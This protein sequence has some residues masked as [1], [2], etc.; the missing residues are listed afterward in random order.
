MAV[1]K[2]RQNGQ[3]VVVGTG[4]KGEKGDAGNIKDL[5]TELSETSTNAV[6]NKVITSAVSNLIKQDTLSYSQIQP[7]LVNNFQN[8]I[9]IEMLVE[10]SIGIS[11]NKCEFA[12]DGNKFSTSS[13]SIFSSDGRFFFTPSFYDDGKCYFIGSKHIYYYR[14][15]IFEGSQYLYVDRIGVPSPD[16]NASTYDSIVLEHGEGIVPSTTSYIVTYYNMIK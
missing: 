13:A 3:W 1:L 9:K 10:S 8:V 14:L 15:A 6:Q 4:E 12:G 16:S 7:F 11:T 2:V 5:D